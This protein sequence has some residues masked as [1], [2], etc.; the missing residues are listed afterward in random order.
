[1]TKVVYF[2]FNFSWKLAIGSINDIYETLTGFL[3]MKLCK[4]NIICLFHVVWTNLF[5]QLFLCGTHGIYIYFFFHQLNIAMS[6]N[7][8]ERVQIL[9]HAHI[10]ICITVLEKR[11]INKVKPCCIVVDRPAILVQISLIKV[12]KVV[13]KANI[14]EFLDSIFSLNMSLNF[15]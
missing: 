14:V 12:I 1:V 8:P 9:C 2:Q 15:N 3:S 11:I 4:S 13:W 6:D 5:L 10:N 7:L